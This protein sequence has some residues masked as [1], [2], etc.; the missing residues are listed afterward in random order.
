MS[1]QIVKVSNVTKARQD[2]KDKL[3]TIDDNIENGQA[4]DVF[5]GF[6]QSRIRIEMGQ[7]TKGKAISRYIGRVN[8]EV[9]DRV[10]NY[11]ELAR[12]TGRSDHSIKRWLTIYENHSDRRAYKQIAEDE[13]SKWTEKVFIKMRSLSD[14]STTK[15]K[16]LPAEGKLKSHVRAITTFLDDEDKFEYTSELE[17]L[18]KRLNAIHKKQNQKERN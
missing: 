10:V 13:A 14:E 7:W 15:T 16:R 2:L 3:D 8:V 12:A 4:V 1:K 9:K 5:N 11:S 6:Y 18:R 17:E